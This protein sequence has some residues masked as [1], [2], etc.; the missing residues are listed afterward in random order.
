MKRSFA[1]LTLVIAFNAIAVAQSGSNNFIP[2]LVFQNP[3]LVSGVAGEDG[4]VYKFS[5]VAAEIDATVKVRARSASNVVLTN[6]DVANMGWTKALQPQ[7]GIQGNVLANQ[8]WWMDFDVVFYKAGTTVRKKIKG[9][10]VT[11]IDVDGDGVSIRE[12]IQMN[13]VSAVAYCPVNYL[14]P[15]A[16]MLLSNLAEILTDSD[17]NKGSDKMSLGPVQN[18]YN[19]DTAGTPVMSTYTYEDKDMI[20]F[21][22]GAKSGAVISN[23]GER[24]NSLWF[25]AFNL[26]PPSLLPI[27]FY[28][29][30]AIYDKKQVNLSWSAQADDNVGSFVIER[31][32]DGSYFQPVGNVAAQ[33]S[34]QHYTFTDAGVSAASGIVYYR[35][36]SREKTGEKNYSAI[37]LIRLNKEANASLAVYPNPVQGVANLTL[38]ASWQSKPVAIRIF[39]SAGMQVKTISL[40]TASQTESVDFSQLPAGMYVVKAQCR[41]ELAEQRVIRN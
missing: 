30:N 25:K 31:S 5:N 38:P 3:E 20:T 15:Q 10:Q 6:I 36:Q 41:D 13:R 33:A 16:P 27:V 18:F 11:A 19:I 9:F 26:T 34:L 32:T 4:A 23:A 28:S 21:R 39:N 22:Y 17:N 24:L 14:A 29:F 8:D 35:I 7:F 1:V 37:K 12:Y 2:E 40:P